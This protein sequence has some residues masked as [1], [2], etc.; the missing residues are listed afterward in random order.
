MQARIGRRAVDALAPTQRDSFLWDTDMRGFGVKCTPKGRKVYI[1][2]YQLGGRGTPL[3]RMTIGAHGSPWTPERARAEAERILAEVALGGDPAGA[4][5]KKRSELTV[6][7]VADR[8]LAEHVSIHNR[9]STAKE[10]SRI[11]EKRI[12]P[13]LGRIKI[14]ELTRAHI[15]AWHYKMHATPYEANRAL[16]YCSK[17]LN[18]AANDWELRTDNPCRGIKRYAEAK[19][20]RYLSDQELS[21][22]GAALDLARRKR[23]DL[24]GCI[25]TV[26][27][28]AV[29]GMRLGEVLSLRWEDVD[30]NAGCIRLREEKAKAGARTVPL[31]APALAILSGI[32][33]T[34][35]VCERLC[36]VHAAQNRR[37]W[38]ACSFA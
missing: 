26:R 35:D 14:S 23:A 28:L 21:R 31:S 30:F 27:L 20:E 34:G 10:A 6:A 17:M 33:Q 12:K 19:R 29:T 9:P 36:L 25:D 18:L 8:Y 7:D 24:P 2:Q 13:S 5:A 3:R 1:V 38:L 32:E 11:V 4:R 22:I 37:Q 16:A 15:K